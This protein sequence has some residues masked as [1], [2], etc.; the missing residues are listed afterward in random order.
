MTE[1]TVTATRSAGG[2]ALPQPGLHL[3]DVSCQIDRLEQARN[4]RQKLST[5]QKCGFQF[6]AD[7]YRVSLPRRSVHTTFWRKRKRT[8]VNPARSR[9]FSSHLLAAVFLLLASSI[10]TADSFSS[11]LNFGNI[12]IADGGTPPSPSPARST[13]DSLRSDG[14]LQWADSSTSRIFPFRLTLSLILLW[15]SRMETL[16]LLTGKSTSDR[17]SSA[18][19]PDK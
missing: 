14:T 11:T 7:R 8:M 19:S 16:S 10:A 6:V 18:S 1:V 5:V 13:M 3:H 4:F 9:L 12:N 17:R 15:C 2:V